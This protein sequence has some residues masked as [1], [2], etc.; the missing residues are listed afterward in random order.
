MSSQRTKKFSD[1]LKVISVRKKPAWSTNELSGK[2]P[3]II[4][5]SEA[6][7]DEET[8]Y[9][10]IAPLT[11]TNDQK[12]DIIG[13]KNN[14][15]S[16]T[17]ASGSADSTL[18][19][20][21]RFR[22]FISSS[23]FDISNML[24]KA[25]RKLKD[26]NIRLGLLLAVASGLLLTMYS[27][28]LGNIKNEIDKNMVLLLRG[29]LQSTAMAGWSLYQGLSFFPSLSNKSKSTSIIS[30]WGIALCTVVIAGAR[31]SCIFQAWTMIS[32]AVVQSITNTSPVLVMLLSHVI[33]DDRLTLISFLCGVGYVLGILCIFQIF[34]SIFVGTLIINSAGYT[35]GMVALILTSLGQIFT[36]M[37]TG[38]FTKF[39]ILCYDG[40]AISI[41]AILLLQLFPSENAPILPNNPNVWAQAALI[42]LLGNMQQFCIVWALSLE[43]TSRVAMMR[44]V[45]IVFS[46]FVDFL[47]GAEFNLEQ[48]IG[49]VIIMTTIVVH[50]EEFSLKKKCPK[51][52]MTFPSC[53]IVQFDSRS[54][55]AANY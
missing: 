27:F 10:T 37:M 42:A 53:R 52:D 41:A 30:E 9:G 26:T 19:S 38:S 8:E 47:Q 12:N 29:V 31:M 54:V 25:F 13:G 45:S 21:P 55:S 48:I 51:L 16:N 17:L 35:F 3:L 6:A 49:G 15:A 23:I 36:K 34:E 24:E 28:I 20:W 46:F 4:E 18:G 7:P 32:I 5:E 2:S 39:A 50:A 43:T 11:K 22:Q 44:S 14:S 33:L 1:Y 40:I